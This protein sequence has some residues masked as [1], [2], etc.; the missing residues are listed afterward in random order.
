MIKGQITMELQAKEAEKLAL[1]YFL[2]DWEITDDEHDFF[3]VLD[4]RPV[5]DRWYVV[6]IGI[7][8]LP[9]S[10]AEI[11]RSQRQDQQQLMSS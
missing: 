10:L 8:G 9:E 3:V 11:L 2:E 4:S 6:E 1:D 5:D 7:E